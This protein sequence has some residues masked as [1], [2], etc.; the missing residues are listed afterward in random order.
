MKKKVKDVVQT[1]DSRLPGSK[2]QEMLRAG[3][4]GDPWG[5]QSAAPKT[6]LPVGE[7]L[8]AK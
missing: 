4:E 1:P 2:A 3:T 8:G 5:Q 7:H 6:H